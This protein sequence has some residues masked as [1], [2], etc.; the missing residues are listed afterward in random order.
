VLTGLLLFTL[1]LAGY[2]RPL[3]TEEAAASNDMP[4]TTSSSE[5]RELFLQ[6]RDYRENWHMPQALQAWQNA[7]QKDPNF[8]LAYL[9]IS[10]HTPDPKA[11]AEARAIAKRL[12]PKASHAEQLMIQ[13]FTSAK[14]GNFV[15][16]IAAMNDLVELYPKDKSL[17][18]QA[19]RWLAMQR[20]WDRGQSL[21]E[22][23]LVIDPDYAAALNQLGYLYASYGPQFDK[24]FKSFEHYS[25]LRPK[26]PNPQDSWA[27]VLRMAGHYD[28][29]LEHY[30]KSLELDPAY[31]SSQ[32]GIADTYALMGDEARAR[33]EYEKVIQAGASERTKIN[34][35]NQVALTYLREGNSDEAAQRYAKSA[36]RAHEL[37]FSDVE[38]EC[39]RFMAM[40]DPNF[41]RAIK[42]LDEAEKILLGNHTLAASNLQNGLSRILYV[43]AWRAA[44]A[45][46]TSVASTAVA[47]LQKLAN[48]SGNNLILQSY[49]A[50]AGMLSLAQ[51]KY[52]DAVTHL[53]EDRYTHLISMEQLA[54]AYAKAGN[55]DDAAKL[56]EEIKQTNLPNIEQV[57]VVDPLRK[58]AITARQ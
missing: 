2:A 12:A 27:E 24:S 18:F 57:L 1:S 31:L 9:F 42:H 22:R 17:L 51:G 41:E 7:V 43:R 46:K 6:G 30:R 20:R 11:E 35:L 44:K 49:H 50:A 34:Y 5:A 56:R 4:M 21:L 54:L 8:A 45:G 58:A 40:F 19:G 53:E 10:M 36:Q 47:G 52:P 26:E 3:P 33:T 16:A 38:A 14:E 55:R 32:L 39:H 29:A 28:Q 48:T 15:A 25:A 23:A 37:G 13:W